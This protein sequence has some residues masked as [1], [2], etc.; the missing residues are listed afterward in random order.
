MPVL[1]YVSLTEEF[2]CRVWR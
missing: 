2:L 1:H